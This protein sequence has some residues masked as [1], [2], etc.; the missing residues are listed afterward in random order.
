M[1]YQESTGDEES[2]NLKL[3]IDLLNKEW[4]KPHGFF[5]ALREGN[6]DAAKAEQMGNLLES[7]KLDDSLVIDRRFVS[8]VWYIPLF[9]S[10]QTERVAERGGD[11]KALEKAT[12]RIQGIIEGLLG[13]P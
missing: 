9:M 3:A 12:N 6:F 11:T 13:V 2:M 8:L 7:I 5:G 10:W 1:L 4:E